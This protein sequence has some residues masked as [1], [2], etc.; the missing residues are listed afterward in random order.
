MKLRKLMVIPAMALV[1][2]LPM[3]AAAATAA[4]YVSVRDSLAPRYTYISDAFIGISP[5]DTGVTV[6]TS[7]S[8]YS[9]VTKITGT[10]TLYRMNNNGGKTKVKSW[11]L[12]TK[13]SE[14]YESRSVSVSSGTYL[15]TFSGKVFAG[16]DSESIFLD[17][18][19]DI[20]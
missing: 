11:S 6:A 2:V 10:M 12:S 9:E 13:G 19:E 18:E 7:V 14:L 1:L 4:P 5:T 17:V 3:E 8:G 15:V 20:S 16:S